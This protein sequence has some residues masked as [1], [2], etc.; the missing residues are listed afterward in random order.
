MMRRSASDLGSRHWFEVGSDADADGAESNEPDVTG[1]YA[2]MAALEILQTLMTVHGVSGKKNCILIYWICK[3]DL[4]LLKKYGK[5]PGAT[6]GKYQEH[7]DRVN[8][9]DRKNHC[10]YFLDL[11]L[12][13][14]F[15]EIR[16]VHDVATAPAHELLAEEFEERP[17]VR[18]QLDLEIANESL[19]P[20]YY[21]HPVVQRGR[22]MGS[23]YIRM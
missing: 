18:E 4:S 7:L 16:G 23:P 3:A 8:G 12:T 20:C 21:S 22:M 14:K 1:E 10:H 2:A 11:P 5:A 15:D 13:R 9:Y 17:E 19:P 6:T